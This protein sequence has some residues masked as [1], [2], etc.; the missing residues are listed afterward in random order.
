M[1]Q[2]AGSAIVETVQTAKVVIMRKHDGHLLV[3]W[4]SIDDGWRPGEPD[5]PGGGVEVGESL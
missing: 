5:L 4:R 3:L 2:S 1:E